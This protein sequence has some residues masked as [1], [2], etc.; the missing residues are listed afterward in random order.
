MWMISSDERGKKH[1]QTNIRTFQN[2]L[3]INFTYSVDSGRQN[4]YSLTSLV[5]TYLRMDND[6]TPC[7]VYEP[8]PFNKNVI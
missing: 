4:R 1:E 5:G 6:D 3:K 2:G 7:N 8:F